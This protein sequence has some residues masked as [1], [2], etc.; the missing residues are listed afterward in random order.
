MLRLDKILETIRDHDNDL[1]VAAKILTV[2]TED[3]HRNDLQ[4]NALSGSC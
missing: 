1:P 3:R 2:R 4:T